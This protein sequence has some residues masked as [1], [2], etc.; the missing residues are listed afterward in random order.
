MLKFRTMY[1]DSDPSMH[2]EFVTRFIRSAARSERPADDA[3]FK[4]SNDPRV[5]PLGRILRMTSLDELPQFWNV[6]CGQMSLVGPRPPLPYEV[7]LYEPWHWSR[8]TEARPGIT[9]PWQVSGRSRTTFDQMV[10]M[11]IR[12]ARRPSLWADV[13]ILLATPWAAIS[14]KGAR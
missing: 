13:R 2:R 12:Y 7:E 4:L 1:W 6:L 10:R 9:G 11:D 5:T 14:G 8:V 3:P